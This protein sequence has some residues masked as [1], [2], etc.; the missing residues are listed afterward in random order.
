M[1]VVLHGLAHRAPW[2]HVRAISRTAQNIAETACKRKRCREE[3]LSCAEKEEN[4]KTMSLTIVDNNF[5]AFSFMLFHL[6]HWLYVRRSRLRCRVWASRDSNVQSH[7]DSMLVTTKANTKAEM[8]YT[9]LLYSSEHNRIISIRLT[10]NWKILLNN[11]QGF[12]VLC[13]ERLW[14]GLN[15]E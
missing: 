6:R 2:N 15:I 3:N 5:L 4:G 11:I 9:H 12:C 8:I 10:C 7:I 14:C 1:C 13:I